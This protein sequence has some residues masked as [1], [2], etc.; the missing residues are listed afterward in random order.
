MTVMKLR[1][2]PTLDGARWVRFGLTQ[3]LRQPLPH[4]ALFGFM[5]FA[6]SLLLTLPWIGPL[7]ALALLPALNAGWVHSTDCALQGQTLTPLSLLVPLR[8][9]Q[10]DKLL[11]LGAVHATAALLMFGL[12]DL[13]DP[14]FRDQWGQALSGQADDEL[15]ARA[16]EAVQQGMLL[17][18][19]MLLPVL[20]LFWHAPVIIYRT[21]SG[22]AKALFASALATLR[23]LG[24]FVV[25]GLT[26]IAADLLLSTVV[27]ALLGLIGQSSFAIL[28]IVPTSML[29]SAG[30][31]AS[32]H[33]SVH[34][35]IEFDDAA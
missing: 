14:T 21:G 32:L 27:G 30:F 19:A 18:A 3:L 15:A 16:V 4:A 33:A 6:F 17:R 8:S 5:A 25:Y 7:L 35:C 9:P 22:V 34:G 24:A 20:L 2:A 31:F 29:F 10:R 12:S 11:M 28:I 1:T 23:N 13:I 26:W